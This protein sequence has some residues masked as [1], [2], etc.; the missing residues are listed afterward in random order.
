MSVIPENHPCFNDKA[1]HTYGRVHLPVAPSCNIQCNFC[2][3]KYDCVNESR[4]GVSSGT[5]KPAQA[6]AYLNEIMSR[7][8]N[9]SVVGIAGPG[10]PFANAEATMETLRLVRE[11]YPDIMLCVATNGLNVLPFVDELATLNVS[12]VTVTINSVDKAVAA[13]IYSWVRYGGRVRFGE[14][15]TYFLVENQLAAVKALK[16]KSILVKVNSILI[17]GINEEQVVEVARVTGEM[18]A[19]IFNCL[20]YYKNEGCNFAD[21][22]EPAASLIADVRKKASK[23]ISQMHHCTRCRADAVGLIGEGI[24]EENIAAL[25]KACSS[26][27]EKKSLSIDSSRSY[28]A[29]GTMEGMLINRH[30]GEASD[31]SIYAIDDGGEVRFIERRMTPSAGGGDKRWE[32]LA[33]VLSDCAYIF[34][35]GAGPRPTEVLENFGIKVCVLEGVIEEALSALFKGDGLSKMVKRDTHKCGSGCGG[36]GMGCM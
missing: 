10:D 17:P 3:R 34:V 23:Y 11:A 19:D 7:T 18:G 16:E 2:N 21:I 1:R 33:S 35:S 27:E 6:L 13:K 26:V 36:N 14:E 25:Q 12:H 5:L 24:S 32:S 15:G 31:L 22:D 20:P 8:D 29:V 28:V 9:I 4:P 30:L